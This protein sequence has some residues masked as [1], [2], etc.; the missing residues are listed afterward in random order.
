V[1]GNLSPFELAVTFAAVGVGGLIQGSIGFGFALV[2]APILALLIPAA[3]PTTLLILAVPLNGF[4]AVRER[5][6]VDLAGAG[7]LMA[8]RVV[9]TLAGAAILISVPPRT[10]SAVF[11]LLI[12]AAVLAT[13]MRPPSHANGPKRFLAGLASGIMATGAGVGGPPVALVYGDRSG[14]EL[15]STLAV[16]F[17]GGLVVSLTTLALAHMVSAWQ[18]LLALQLVPALGLGLVLSRYSATFLDRRF[19]RPC[20]LGFAFLSG[21]AAILRALLP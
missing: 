7:L 6:H 2:A 12:L 11:G 13:L 15:R 9:G 10:L 19:L 4:V 20:I 18:V 21:I 8:G 14:P 1:S 3:L 16:F 17:L 5:R